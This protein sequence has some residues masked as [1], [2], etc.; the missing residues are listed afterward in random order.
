MEMLIEHSMPDVVG[1]E[2]IRQAVLRQ[3]IPHQF[4]GIIPFAD[5]IVGDKPI[6]GTSY[7]P[8]GS[9]KLMNLAHQLGFTGLYFDPDKFR[10]S[11]WVKNRRDLLNTNVMTVSNAINALGCYA[12]GHQFFTRPND[13]L[14]LF[15]GMVESA[16]YLFEFFQSSLTCAS[17][18]SAK[19]ELD[20]LVVLE[21]PSDIDVEWRWFIVDG[22]VVDGS[23]YRQNGKLKPEHVGDSL[24]LYEAQTLAD[25]WLPH[26]CCVMDVALVHGAYHVLEFNT[27]NCSGFYNHNVDLIVSKLWQYANK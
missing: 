2:L 20:T 12:P 10:V 4:V 8:F 22:Q 15:S 16:E 11:E 18:K 9:N 25:K 23:R 17:S 19:L 24:M 21:D 26:E 1:L 3:N 6:V 27:I 14:K 13:D 5:E 7:Q